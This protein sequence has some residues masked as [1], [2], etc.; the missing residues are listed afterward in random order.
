MRTEFFW[1]KIGASGG[2]SC[3]HGNETSSSVKKAR[4]L[5]FEVFAASWTSAL[6]TDAGEW[7]ISSSDRLYL[8]RK[9]HSYT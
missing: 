6:D 1:F 2:G 9:S 7:G 8:L 3:E 4:H 5:N